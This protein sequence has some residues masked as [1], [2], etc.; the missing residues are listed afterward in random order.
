MFRIESRNPK[1]LKMLSSLREPVALSFCVNFAVSG[2]RKEERNTLRGERTVTNVE[3]KT[4][5]LRS[6]L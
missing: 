5:L 1:P 3:R 6:V 2:T 4:I